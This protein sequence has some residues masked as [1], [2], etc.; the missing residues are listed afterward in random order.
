MTLLTLLG[1]QKM[2]D[3]NQ[4]LKLIVNQ[5]NVKSALVKQM[6][7]N[8]R[9][10][11]FTIQNMI[12]T[13]DPFA[14][15]EAA[16]SIDELGAN[17][18]TA[19]QQLMS[20][21]LEPHEKVML[22][23]Q[24]EWAQQA[25]PLQR[26]AVTLIISGKRDE[27]KT[28]LAGQVLPT[29]Q[30]VLATLAQLEAKQDAAI[31]QTFKE[32][33][34]THN[35]ARVQIIVL[36][37]IASI[38]GVLIA[39]FTIHR[40][41]IS[42]QQLF[43]E[44]ER[45]QVTLHSIGDGVITTDAQGSIEY[46]NPVAEQLTGWCS[47]MV[48]G[49]ALLDIFRIVEGEEAHPIYS[50][51]EQLLAQS[52]Q[53]GPLHQSMLLDANHETTAIEFTA[54]A[55]NDDTMHLAGIVVTFRDVSEIRALADHL[56]HQARHD[57]LTNLVNR[58]EFELRL[59]QALMHAHHEKQQH[60]L[61]FLDLDRFK[62]VNDTCGHAAGD[63]L[64]IQ[65]VSRL[66]TLVRSNDLLARLGGD[67]FGLLLESCPLEKASAIAEEIRNSVNSFVFVWEKQSFH[68]G[69]SIGMVVIDANSGTLSEVIA[70][71]DAACYS[72]KDG[73]RN[74]VHLYTDSGERKQAELRAPWT[75][76]LQTALQDDSF[77]LYCQ[78]IV[79]VNP[80]REELHL[81]ELQ[82]RLKDEQG[83][84]IPPMAFIPAA[85]RHNL[86]PAID[87]WVLRHTC[88]LINLVN[89]PTAIYCLNLSLQTVSD[90]QFLPAV[91]QML[92]THQV[93]P[94]QICFEITETHAVSDLQ[95]IGNFVRKLRALGCR[96]ALDDV[97]RS[98]GSYDYLKN[99]PVDFIKIDGHLIGGVVHS[100]IS[101]VQVKAIT[102]IAHLLGICVIAEMVED[103][104]TLKLLGGLGINYAQGFGIAKPR[105]V[106]ELKSALAASADSAG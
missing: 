29:Q 15:D 66:R 60:A 100:T 1:L 97:G 68:V 98:I 75:E 101:N 30:K 61:C 89:D 13:D 86:M 57:P 18:T 65:L 24:S 52:Q 83:Q 102:Q 67:E 14:L 95:K 76:R 41:R 58:R 54:S 7:L 36:G 59:E 40:S 85:E 2:A 77:V 10:R 53:D 20:M 104:H 26:E 90:E 80:L 28:L 17:F 106:A 94:Q 49:K 21:P 11:V 5:H 32:A 78:S 8:A 81:C 31:E 103:H 62:I 64:L 9:E 74:R 79:A 45:A 42:S 93:E 96:S 72:A 27:A 33:V 44:K 63:A 22:N 51:L 55:I 37:G 39:L 69:V 23:I 3:I 99:L 47:T 105:P 87:R 56:S 35:Q 34:A 16:L 73:G 4:Q 82:L 12:L 91:E 46:M 70:M 19:R 88:Q 50:G 92:R 6:S 43:R 71:A 84:Q 48:E 25:V 38:L